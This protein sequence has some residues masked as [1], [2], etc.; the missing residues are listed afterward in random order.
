MLTHFTENIMMRPA[1]WAAGF[2]TK[3][4]NRLKDTSPEPEE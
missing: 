3:G 4:I 2:F 1:V